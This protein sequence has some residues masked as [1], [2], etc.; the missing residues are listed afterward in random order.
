MLSRRLIPCLDVRDG[1]VVK[2]VQFKNHEDMGGIVELAAKYAHAD[3]LVFYDITA[4]TEGRSVDVNWVESVAKHISIPFCVAGGIDSMEKAHR[5]LSSG[6]DKVSLNTPAVLNPGLIEE[7]SG[8]FGSQAITIGID[9]CFRD[10][11]YYIHSHTGN[12]QT[13]RQQNKKT[14]EWIQQVQDL[15][16]GEI[17]LNCMGDDGRRKGYDLE[18]LRVA[19]SLCRV[20]LVASG[21][22]GT[23]EHFFDVFSQVGVSGALA[24]SVFHKNIFTVE[25]LREYLRSKDI[26]M[27]SL[28]EPALA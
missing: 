13:L 22:A 17:V 18:Q 16:A 9:S 2:G 19:Q 12:E 5:V 3:E 7:L 26:P 25:E 11:D 21:G 15:G 1:R 20:P 24:A 27:R 23:M 14:T 10:G 28:Y 4:S 8:K 6:A